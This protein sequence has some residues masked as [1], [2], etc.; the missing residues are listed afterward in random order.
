[1]A[2][3]SKSLEWL[4]VGPG[5]AWIKESKHVVE[6]AVLQHDLNDVLDLRQLIG[7]LGL[8]GRLRRGSRHAHMLTDPS[9]VI[10]AK[11][12]SDP[13]AAALAITSCRRGTAFRYA[14]RPGP[15]I[16]ADTARNRQN[17]IERMR[18]DHPPGRLPR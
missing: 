4:P 1:M 5:L 3:E 18:G 8:A 2:G 13:P 14:G 15:G 9:G 17:W 16:K 11:R 12:H 7:L 6:R 10:N